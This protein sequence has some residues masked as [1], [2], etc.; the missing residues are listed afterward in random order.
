MVEKTVDKSLRAYIKPPG[1]N[2]LSRIYVCF[3]NHVKQWIPTG[4]KVM[5]EFWDQESQYVKIG[6]PLQK[7]LNA[8]LREKKTEIAKAIDDLIKAKIDPTTET[9]NDLIKPKPPVKTVVSS[10]PTLS[11]LLLEYEKANV[12]TLKK[13]YLRNYGQVARNLDLYK[14]GVLSQDFTLDE[15]SGFITE[16]LIEDRE[17]ENN[18]ISGYVRR[19]R[20]V[21]DLACRRGLITNTDYLQFKHKYVKPKPFWLEWAEV[22]LLE[23]YEAKKADYIYKE[24]FLFRCYTGLRWS[25]AHGLGPEHFIKKDGKVFYDFST[26]KTSLS[27]NIQMSSKAVEIL[28]R[29]GYK[30][31]KLY[32]SDCNEKIKDICEGAGIKTIVEKVRFR[33]SE[34]LVSLLPKHAMVTTHV[35]RRSFARR[36]MD[37]GGT[38]G[39]LMRYLGHHSI[40]QTSD[41]VGYTTKEVNDELGKLMG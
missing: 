11:S 5:P 40:E 25:D 32:L 8:K 9:V 23:A 36:W 39:M 27:E 14:P 35:A 7:Q 10:S 26:V 12:S 37:L 24:E 31:P 19:I 41:Y 3:N 15:L 22:E 6:Q 4:L 33:G 28:D 17:I 1:A 30:I 38:I 16:H 2:G 29:W 18:T 20:R 34:R 21:M 13:G